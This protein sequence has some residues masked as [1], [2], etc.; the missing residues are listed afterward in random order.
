MP[1]I[2]ALYSGKNKIIKIF[3]GLISVSFA[4]QI[5]VLPLIA[6]YFNKISFI[7][8]VSNLIIVPLAGVIMATGLVFCAF[9]ILLPFLA[10]LSTSMA[11]VNLVLIKAMLFLVGCFSS[12]SFATVRTVTPSIFS[13][14]LYYVF[15]V[16]A[17]SLS[18]SKISKYAM[19]SS[20]LLLIFPYSM[21]K[22]PSHRLTITV[23]DTGN[24]FCS[25]I[26][27]PD[28]SNWLINTGQGFN[29]ESDEAQRIIMPYLWQKQIANLDRVILTNT[30]QK[31]C[32]S[33]IHIIEN[34]KIGG[35]ILPPQTAFDAGFVEQ[36]KL[37][38]KKKIPLFE[39]WGQQSYLVSGA[40][41]S[42]ISPSRLHTERNENSLVFTVEYEGRR[43]LFGNGMGKWSEDEVL[44]KCGKTDVDIIPGNGIRKLNKKLTDA[45]NPG[46]F[47]ISTALKNPKA[48]TVVYPRKVYSTKTDGA[49]TVSMSKNVLEIKGFR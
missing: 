26:N 31:E 13:I 19:L 12:F 34:F 38:D 7:G 24:T 16:S 25:H 47:I 40:T 48:A 9:N 43:V 33:F 45:I 1:R 18:K 35:V 28:G 30:R 3:M 6:F 42:F 11:W 8:F 22:P 23:L 41:I 21:L 5:S 46:Y 17:F 27:F 14:I 2:Y 29:K 49:I 39:T 44:S 20:F 37:M 4:A 32:G 10:F 36:L 15:I